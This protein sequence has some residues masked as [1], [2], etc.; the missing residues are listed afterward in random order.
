[1]EVPF[2]HLLRAKREPV[3]VAPGRQLLGLLV[4]EVHGLVLRVRRLETA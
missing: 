4:E 1:M 2:V 3:G